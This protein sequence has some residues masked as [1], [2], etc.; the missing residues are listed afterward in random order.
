[1][2]MKATVRVKFTLPY[3]IG[4]KTFKTSLMITWFIIIIIE[5][6]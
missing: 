2:T 1:M 6:E 5:L 3:R 4:I